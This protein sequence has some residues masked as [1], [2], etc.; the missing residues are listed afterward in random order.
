[1]SDLYDGVFHTVVND[2]KRFVLPFINE[3]FGEHYTGDEQIEFRP[4]EHFIDQL[5][6]PDKKRIT[7]SNFTVIGKTTKKYHLECESS[8]HSGRIL[9]RLFEYDSQ[10]ALDESEIVEDKIEVTFPNTAVLYLRN[11]TKTPDK[12]R[13][14]IRV[15]GDSVEYTVPIAKI[16]KYAIDDIFDKKLYMLIPFYIFVYESNFCIYDKDE[17]KL[18]QL[19]LE[20]A[21][22]I[23]RLER[24]T[25]TGEIDAFDKRTII[26]LSEDV[27][28]ELTCKYENVQKEIGDIMGG[29]ALIETEARKLKNEGRLEGKNE[30]ISAILDARSGISYEELVSK[31][32]EEDA[33]SAMQLK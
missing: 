13:V 25:E 26:E 30:I 12:M 6:E 14:I 29:A 11:T 21:N 23:E 33:K 20:Y 24:L 31:Y 9:I 32:G 2:C 28:R 22:I 18:S 5:D 27:I 1:M 19:K 4:N 17:E 16:A 3:V 10:I 8:K 15:P 7:D